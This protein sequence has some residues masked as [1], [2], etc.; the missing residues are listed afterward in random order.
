[1]VAP[2][3]KDLKD[4]AGTYWLDLTVTIPDP[5]KETA[6]GTAPAV[7]SAPPVPSPPAPAKVPL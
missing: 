4:K 6:P 2:G 1:M 7:A 3:Y 5:K